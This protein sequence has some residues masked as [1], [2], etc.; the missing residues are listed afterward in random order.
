MMDETKQTRVY[1]IIMWSG[2]A[3]LLLTAAYLSTVSVMAQL[4]PRTLERI[5][6]CDIGEVYSHPVLFV[7]FVLVGLVMLLATLLY[8]RLDLAHAGAW[9]SHSGIVTLIVGAA[10]YALLVQQGQCITI[11]IDDGDGPA[12]WSPI[13]Y[14]EPIR[15]GKVEEPV[16]LGLTMQVLQTKFVSRGS[17][18][19]DYICNVRTGQGP[20][21]TE[22]TLSLNNPIRAGRFQVTQGSWLPDPEHPTQIV[23]LVATRPMIGIIWLGM[24]MTVAGM[25]LGFYVRPLIARRGRGSYDSR[26]GCRPEPTGETPG[27]RDGRERGK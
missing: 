18:P 4:S 5:L 22:Q 2:V 21:A 26:P 9:L 23:F 3:L 10:G 27:A 25:L 20:Q 8:V 14:F 11:R 24:G 6:H 15:G 19:G 12:Q 13:S 7:L 16:P 17:M 1:K